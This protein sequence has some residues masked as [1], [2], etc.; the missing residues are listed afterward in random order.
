MIV[1][2]REQFGLAGGEP[3]RD[4]PDLGAEM[5]GIG[6]DRTQ[7]LGVAGAKKSTVYWAVLRRLP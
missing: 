1:R 6:G 5:L 4:E 7:R 3:H 2:H